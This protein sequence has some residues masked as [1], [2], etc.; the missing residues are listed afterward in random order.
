VRPV[1]PAARRPQPE[2]AAQPV[3]PQPA[4]APVVQKHLVWHGVDVDG[5]GQEDFTNPTGQAMREHDGYGDGRFGA[6]R[7]G[8]GREHEGVDYVA[9]AGQEVRAPISGYVTRIG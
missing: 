4:I 8:G 5:D 1:S 3:A 6:S 9:D 2:T 7:D